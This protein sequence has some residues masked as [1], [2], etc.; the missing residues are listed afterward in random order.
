[1]S[2]IKWC[3]AGGHPFSAND[4]EAIEYAETKV[5]E[6]GQRKR[7]DVCGPC[8]SNNTL[9]LQA[10]GVSRKPIGN[11]PESSGKESDGGKMEGRA[12]VPTG[13]D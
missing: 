8:N 10:F 5:D 2:G 3:D 6:H 13:D 1:M 4:S 7:I 9:N 12:T 11:G